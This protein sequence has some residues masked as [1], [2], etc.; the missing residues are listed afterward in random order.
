MEG[1]EGQEVG[2]GVRRRHRS[3]AVWLRSTRV[4]RINE[5]AVG[6]ILRRSRTSLPCRRD[7]G[8]G[9]VGGVAG[10]QRRIVAAKS[11]SMTVTDVV[12]SR[13]AYGV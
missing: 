6:A 3:V 2:V 12:R 5:T 11:Q 1:R 4:L 8:Q 13:R 10:G 7:C 9:R